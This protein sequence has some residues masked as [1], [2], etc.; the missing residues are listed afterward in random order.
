MVKVNLGIVSHAFYRN[1]M[2]NPFKLN[3]HVLF[4]CNRRLVS[5]TTEEPFKSNTTT[6]PTRPYMKYIA[7]VVVAGTVYKAYDYVNN[8]EERLNYKQPDVITIGAL[9]KVSI[10]RKIVNSNDK[11]NLD[12]ILFQC[13]TC[14]FCC[15]M[16][17]YLDSK[18]FSYSVVDVDVLFERNLKW[19]HWKTVPCVL[20]RSK[21]GTYVE[22]TNSTVI[23]S[24]LTAILNDPEVDVEELAKL[25]PKIA[26]LKENGKKKHGIVNKYELMYQEKLPKGVTKESMM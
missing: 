14:P 16:L 10:K 4:Q 19:S 22:L 12:L 21:Q 13:Q 3:K 1:L 17:A 25:Y 24:I 15:K 5:N 6:R 7:A 11:T 26:Y 20:A 8:R 2:Q 23:I 18:G 9:P